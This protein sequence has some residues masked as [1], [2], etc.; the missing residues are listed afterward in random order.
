MQGGKAHYDHDYNYD[1]QLFYLMRY[2]IN[3][4]KLL[5]ENPQPPPP[6][7][8]SKIASPLLFANIEKFLTPF[9]PPPCRKW[10]WHCEYLHN[11]FCPVVR[12]WCMLLRF[13]NCYMYISI[14]GSFF[15]WV[16]NEITT[17]RNI[18][19][20]RF[21]LRTKCCNRSWK[22]TIMTTVSRSKKKYYYFQNLAHS[23]TLL[24]SKTPENL[25]KPEVLWCFQ[26]V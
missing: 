19:L 18:R 9:P 21:P 16:S 22:C 24:S 17:W 1:L 6:L 20:L 2:L 7:K 3:N 5:P 10:G 13:S 15:A 8:N 4:W 25:R 14:S 12:F 11:F 23:M 26:G